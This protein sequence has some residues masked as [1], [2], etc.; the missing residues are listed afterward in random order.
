MKCWE[1]GVTALLSLGLIGLGWSEL[2][3][4]DLIE[5]LGFITGVANVWLSVKENV[6][7]WPIGIA[8]NGFL[9]VIFVSSKLYADSSVQIISIGLGFLGW[10]WWLHGG[11][12][13][14]ELP[15]T[16]ILPSE[17][18]RLSFLSLIVTGLLT[19]GLTKINDS[20]PFLD[21]LATTLSLLAQYLMTRK[22][23]ENWYIWIAVD[24]IYVGLYA[25]REL[26][27]TSALYTLSMAMCLVGLAQWQK[28]VS[29]QPLATQDFEI[30]GRCELE[31]LLD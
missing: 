5:G 15:I 23:L 11:Q 28:S 18:V 6:W 8:N 16:A 29:H 26:Y 20:A 14:H 3:R 4:F 24:I 27:L 19:V 30:K 12:D 13:K 1:V 22:L 17:L 9:L 2:V 10:Y 25:W 31:A 21:A 7:N